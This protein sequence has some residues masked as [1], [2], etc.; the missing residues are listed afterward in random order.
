MIERFWNRCSLDERNTIAALSYG[1]ILGF[2]CYF[3]GELQPHQV[4]T[5]Q[6]MLGLTAVL[7]GL[8][9][10]YWQRHPEKC[11]QG[12]FFFFGA[13]IGLELALRSI[14]FLSGMAL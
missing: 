9:V 13:A 4:H 3:L 11:V 12:M 14:A 5:W 2:C 10:F 1:L 6:T 8:P 7:V